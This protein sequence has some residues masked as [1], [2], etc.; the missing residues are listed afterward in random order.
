MMLKPI[1]T[2][3]VPCHNYAHYLPHCMRS[4]L[5]QTDV[6]VDVFV[7][8]DASTDGSVDVASKIARQDSR[9]RLVSLPDN[10]G[11]V[12]ALNY[13][14]SHGIGDYFV[15]LD[16]D[17]MLTPGSLRRSLSFFERHP[18]VGFVYGR[19]RHFT[20]DVPPRER[21]GRPRWTVWPGE[22]WLALRYGRAFNCISQPEVV[23]R[24]SALRQAGFYN[25][26]L[27]HT[28]DLEMWLRLAAI[29]PV[30]RINRADQGYYRVHQGSMQRTVNSGLMKDFIGRRDAFL[31]A[32]SAVGDQVHLAPAL[33]RSV[34][35]E[36]AAQAL[37]CCCR[38]FDR[39]RVD[40]VPM[41]ELTEFAFATYPASATLPE[42]K[43]L[44]RRRRQGVRSKWS[45][46][47][48]VL[49]ATRRIREEFAHFRWVRT[50]V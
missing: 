49:S 7:I 16:A 46:G 32:L 18:D 14:L 36:L 50:G 29:A 37:D 23:I 12:P 39:E 5:D 22:H 3:L 8:D 43:G 27:P 10:I 33:E 44:E 20:G 35:K 26:K 6:D 45:P 40:A 13:G 21:V 47:S 42:W 25:L 48:L 19:P 41:L 9:V 1:V 31:S 24:T 4:V 15:K 11:M 17:D 30:G 34:R 28:S 38:A 2:V